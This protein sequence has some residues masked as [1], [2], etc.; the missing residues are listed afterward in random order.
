M[1]HLLRRFRLP[2]RFLLLFF[3]CLLAFPATA[4]AQTVRV[5]LDAE[6]ADRSYAAFGVAGAFRPGTPVG[7]Q[8]RVTDI[9]QNAAAERATNL[10][11][12]WE[13]QNADGDIAE[14]SRLITLTRGGSQSVWLYS[15]LAWDVDPSQI[16]VLRVFESEPDSPSGRGAEVGTATFTPPAGSPFALDVR[17]SAI[18]R[19][20]QRDAGLSGLGF[21]TGGRNGSAISNVHE[22]T[23]IVPITVPDLPDRAMGLEVFEAIVWLDTSTEAMSPDRMSSA[24][25]EA[26]SGWLNAGGHLVIGL[27][28]GSNP[29]NLGAPETGRLGTFI[30]AMRPQQ[31]DD[32]PLADLLGVLSKSQGLRPGRA[33]SDLKL[34][35]LSF[36]NVLERDQ[37]L[38]LDPG[39]IPVMA[40][41]QGEI[42]AARRPVG[43]GHLTMI[44]LDLSNPQLQTIALINEETVNLPQSDVF[45]NPILG[46]RADSPTPR[47]IAATESANELALS[48]KDGRLVD[49]RIVADMISMREAA[50][51]G[52]L[53]ALV[54]FVAYWLVAGPGGFAVLKVNGLVRHAWVSY[55]IAAALFTGLAWVGVTAFRKRE[56]G[57]QHFTVL[58]WVADSGV[59]LPGPPQLARVRSYLS[60]Y[61]PNYGDAEVSLPEPARRDERA[62]VRSWIAPHSDRAA[63]FPNPARYRVD[64]SDLDAPVSFP[65]RATVTPLSIDYI[66]PLDANWGGMIRVD[67]SNPV[68]ANVPTTGSPR[69]TGSLVNGLPGALTDVMLLWSDGTTVSR[70]EYRVIGDPPREIPRTSGRDL[71]RAPYRVFAW[72]LTQNGTSI[73]AGATF[74][75]ASPASLIA[76]H[77]L[78]E[79]VFAWT[80]DRANATANMGVVGGGGRSP[81][82]SRRLLKMLSMYNLL[83]PPAWSTAAGRVRSVDASVPRYFGRDLDLSDWLVRPCI[84]IIGFMDAQ[85]LPVE[86]K[87][88]GQTQRGS[89]QIMVR[90]ILPLDVDPSVRFN[91]I[92]EAEAARRFA[93]DAAARAARAAERDAAND[94]E[95][96]EEVGRPRRP[97]GS[98]GRDDISDLGL[99][100]LESGDGG[101]STED[102]TR[103]R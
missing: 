63:A 53:L 93:E 55:V 74:S 33:S 27:P 72:D 103:C 31:V 101:R 35:L 90:W 14:T 91:S 69:L 15:P 75:V 60:L 95:E 50:T 57:V 43:H 29:W 99:S 6:S 44:G 24:Q 65:A 94:R 102:V 97:P 86:M 47:E 83:T 79:T 64:S 77:S 78:R 61:V 4:G 56:V 49:G 26:L 48:A 18:G 68:T 5:E 54:L 7:I 88:D 59:M 100:M 17:S 21:A 9:S 52:L 36:G 45:W 19:I 22:Q 81:G 85:E 20:G 2:G 84:I 80:R 46:R 39:W 37:S 41:D 58:D 8:V 76:D 11:V 87:V 3:A 30:P 1:T 25:E 98:G 96:E 67:P 89:G 28:M 71:S 12:Q 34:S 23:V 32:V 70:P 92:I 73:P 10:I 82:R 62:T 16:W 13:V 51:A 66:G 42:I 40:T 38:R